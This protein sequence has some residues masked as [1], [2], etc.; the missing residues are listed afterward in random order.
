MNRAAFLFLLGMLALVQEQAG[1][2]T[3][4]SRL[5]PFRQGTRWGYAD[6]TR[7]LVLPVRYDEAGPFVGEI[8]WVRQ[9]SLYGY[10]DGGGNPITPVQYTQAS[11]FKRER[12]TVELNGE[13]FDINLSGRRLTDPAPPEPEIEPLEHGDLVRK[14]GKVGFRFTVGSATVPPEY[15]EIRENYNGL[16]FVRQGNKWGVINSKG[17]LVQPLVYDAI[18]KDGNLVFPAVEREGLW[19]YLD[20]EGNT[21]TELRYRQADPFLGDIARVITASG[22]PGYIDANGQEFFE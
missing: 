12:A 20:E 4:P 3:A 8:A 14:N 22:Q 18:R 17:K 15:D 7:R 6:H 10:I 2:Q 9:G 1:A 13:T 21:L 19:G 11:S 16:L 5:V